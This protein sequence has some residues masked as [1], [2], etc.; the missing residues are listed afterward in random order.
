MRRDQWVACAR[1]PMTGRPL[2]SSLVRFVCGARHLFYFVSV[3]GVLC[4]DSG[5]LIIFYLLYK[6]GCFCFLLFDGGE[7]QAPHHR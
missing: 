4:L 1:Q 7:E 3:E 2:R 6:D 5:A